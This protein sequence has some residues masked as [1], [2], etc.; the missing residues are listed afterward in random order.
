VAARLPTVYKSIG[1][2]GNALKLRYVVFEAQN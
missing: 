2:R 1:T